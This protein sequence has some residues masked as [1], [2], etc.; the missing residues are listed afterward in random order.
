MNPLCNAH[1]APAEIDKCPLLFGRVI[2]NRFMGERVKIPLLPKQSK[3]KGAGQ[4]Q[5][6]RHVAT[7]YVNDGFLYHLSIFDARLP[8]TGLSVLYNL[9]GLLK[10]KENIF[11]VVE[12]T[13]FTDLD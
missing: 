5:W 4:R 11:D 1:Q 12:L 13:F 7:P 8:T 10:L 6:S 3:I 2:N 9:F